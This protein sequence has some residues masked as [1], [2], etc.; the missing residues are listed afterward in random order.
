M[1]KN[2]VLIASSVFLIGTFFAGILSNNGKAGA[3]GSPG[4]NN[5]TQCHNSF[6]VNSGTGS[7]TITSNMSNWEYIP[8]QSYQISVTVAQSSTGLFGL[9]FEA[10]QSSGANAGTLTPG[11]GTQLKNALVSGNQRANIVHTLNGGASAN[12]HT[13]NFTWTAPNS[14]VGVVTFYA[15]G[16]ACNGNGSDTGDRVYTASQVVNPASVNVEEIELT[17]SFIGAYPNPFTTSLNVQ[18]S[19]KNNAKVQINLMDLTGKTVL[20]ES[21]NKISGLH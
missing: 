19:L 16:N 12:T 17:N 7:V 9:G 3:T 20:T 5:C 13:F 15:A 11:T 1:K 21:H 10:L 14:N 18:Y 2:I 8:G 6:T 4:E